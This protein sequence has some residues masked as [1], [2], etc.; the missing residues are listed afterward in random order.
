MK[1]LV[2]GGMTQQGI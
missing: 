2:V 1:Y